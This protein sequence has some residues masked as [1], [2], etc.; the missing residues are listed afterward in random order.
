MDTPLTIEELKVL[1]QARDIAEAKGHVAAHQAIKH[2]LA[3]SYL[4]VEDGAV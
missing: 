1:V 3:E 2:L 4:K